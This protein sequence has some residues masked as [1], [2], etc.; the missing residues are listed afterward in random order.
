MY[1]I[2]VHLLFCI[3]LLE[4][5]LTRVS[6]VFYLSA[7]GGQRLFIISIFGIIKSRH[8]LEKEMASVLIYVYVHFRS[9]LILKETRQ[10][11]FL[12]DSYL[13]PTADCIQTPLWDPYISTVTVFAYFF[14]VYLNILPRIMIS[15]F[16]LNN[17]SQTLLSY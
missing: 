16:C 11:A 10:R 15:S 8:Q 3:F 6:L 1:S 2:Y 4:F 12:E 13:C 7:G 9:S 17:G 5:N 14:L